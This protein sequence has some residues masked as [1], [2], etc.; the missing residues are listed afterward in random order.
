MSDENMK[1]EAF[2]SAR[3]IYDADVQKG[4]PML[5]E[6][7]ENGNSYAQAEVGLYYD[8]GEY[9]EQNMEEAV[10]WYEKAAD[11]GNFMANYNLAGC[12]FNGQGVEKDEDKAIYLYRRAADIGEVDS[13][14]RMG[15]M[16]LEGRGSLEKSLEQA[17]EWWTKAAYQGNKDAIS[18]VSRFGVRPTK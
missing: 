6:L 2:K 10:K 18:Y 12:Y 5:L 3:E 11:Q 1:W 9:C 8:L 17:L 13:Q 4:F 15:F 16:Y 7:A 14:I